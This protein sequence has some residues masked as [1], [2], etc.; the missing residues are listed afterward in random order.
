MTSL[1]KAQKQIQKL[2]AEIM[3]PWGAR[4]DMEITVAQWLSFL[5][6]FRKLQ[7]D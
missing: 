4:I 1:N 5:F 2:S 7:L 3:K 6:R